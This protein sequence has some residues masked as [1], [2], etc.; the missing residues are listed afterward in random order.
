M[1]I[2]LSQFQ[3]RKN[4]GLIAD[5]E[6]SQA[7]VYFSHICNPHLQTGLVQGSLCAA[8]ERNIFIIVIFLCSLARLDS[9]GRATRESLQQAAEHA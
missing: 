5:S 8:G 2:K 7:K 9:R 1:R 4:R 6:P 3:E